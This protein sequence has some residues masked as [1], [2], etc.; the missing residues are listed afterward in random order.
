MKLNKTCGESRAE[1]SKQR[2][3][4]SHQELLDGVASRRGTRRNLNL[5][6]DRGQVPVDGARTDDKLLGYLGIGEPLGY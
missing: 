5:A 3:G 4:T 2:W 1:G 6:I